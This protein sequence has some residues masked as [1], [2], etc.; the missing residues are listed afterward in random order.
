MTELQLEQ[1]RSQRR[2]ASACSC[3]LCVTSCSWWLLRSAAEADADDLRRRPGRG[4]GRRGGPRFRRSTRSMA[5][6]SRSTATTGSGGGSGVLYDPAGYALTNHH[7]VGGRGRG[8]LGGPGRRQ[9][10]SLEADR[11]RSGRRR[12]DHQAGRARRSFPSPRWA[13]ATRSASATGRWRWAIRSSLAEDQRPTVTLG[14]VSGVKRFQEGSGLNQLVYGN[15]IQV[16]SSIN[17]GNSGG[18]LFNLRGQIIGINGRGSFRGAR[19]RQR[20][21]GLRDLVEPDQE[22]HPRAAGHQD[23]PARH[24]RRRLR[25]PRRP[26]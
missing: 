1:Q 20:R 4:Q 8:G 23:R 19:P 5:R 25:Q 15:C 26:A 11:H 12:G 16:D 6:S 18:P 13:T 7:V 22:L 14:I 21:P 2:R 17:P 10:L 3:S 9:A 24:A